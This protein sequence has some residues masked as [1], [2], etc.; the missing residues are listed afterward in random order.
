MSSTQPYDEVDDL[1]R[2]RNVPSPQLIGTP[3]RVTLDLNTLR[4]RGVRIVGRLGGI[5]DGVA[6]FSGS[7]ANV[8]KLADLK[9]GRLLD[10]FDVWATSVGLDAEVEPSHRFPRRRPTRAP[11][12]PWTS[13]GASRDRHLGLRLH[14]PDYSWLH[15]PVLDRRLRVVHDGGV[16]AARPASTCRHAVPPP[17][18]IQL[19]Q[20]R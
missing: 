13:A 12:S 2:A 17:P 5:V 18:P 8:C 14:D 10:T 4:E 9:L 7:L 19:R 15:L 1:V 11:R 16:S 3:Q 20:R 6:Q